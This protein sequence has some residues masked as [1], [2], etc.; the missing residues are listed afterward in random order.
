MQK[1]GPHVPPGEPDMVP[2]D[3]RVFGPKAFAGYSY[4]P[5]EGVR[6]RTFVIEMRATDLIYDQK[7]E[8][9]QGRFSRRPRRRSRRASSV[10][11]Y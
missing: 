1:R 7:P 2:R 5:D 9:L 8:H 10:G 3:Y 6:R 4:T 11:G